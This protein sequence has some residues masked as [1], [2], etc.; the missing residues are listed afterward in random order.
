MDTYLSPYPNHYFTGDGV[1]RDEDG[2]YWVQ[3]RVD[4]KCILN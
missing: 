1:K 4:G 2:Y 3:G